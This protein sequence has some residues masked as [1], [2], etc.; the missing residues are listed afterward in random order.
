MTQVNENNGPKE[1]YW[2][3]WTYYPELLAR[4]V[5]R[6]TSYPTAAEF[7]GSVGAAEMEQELARVGADASLSIYVHIPY[8]REICWYCGCNTGAAN[9]QNRLSAYLEAMEREIALVAGRLS[10]QGIVR[11]IAF[12]GGSPNAIAPVE[13]VRLLQQIL[14]CFRHDDP[15]I[16]VELDPRILN[17][18]WISVLGEAGVH[19]VSMG[20]QTFA[21]HV[22]AAIGRVQPA[23]MIEG[24]VAS[25]RSKGVASI[26]FDLMYGLPGQDIGD[27]DDTLERSIALAPDRIALF[28]Y[29]HVPELLPR[30]RRIDA[31]RLPGQAE[32]FA[33]ASHGHDRLT[34]AGYETIGFDHFA[35]SQDALARAKRQNVLRRNFQGFTAD[36]SEVLIGLG[37]T[38]ISSF[39]G[40][41]IQNEKNSGRY[42]MRLS[43]ARLPAERG[44][45]RSD[46]DR[47]RG[48]VIEDILCRGEARITTDML[49]STVSLEL[50][51]FEQCGLVTLYDAKLR[52][53][54]NA[55]PYAR[56]IAAL[57]DSYRQPGAKK[58]SNAI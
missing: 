29:A 53:A 54:P 10:G 18:Q 11:H 16:A 25:L 12:G 41:I 57:F 14:L 52:L 45:L 58:F 56:S 44:V 13:F 38:A 42:R 20:V 19:R 17:E 5:P 39:S 30:Q 46:T 26:N 23:A 37:A 4:P 55:L 15:E 24:A 49:S 51:R 21:P 9:R 47:R 36:Q 1:D 8:C 34:A 28:G 40:S 7:N 6:Y 3:M 35:L 50:A 22:Q 27:L 43:T 2:R 31:T 33:M 32:R 48:Q